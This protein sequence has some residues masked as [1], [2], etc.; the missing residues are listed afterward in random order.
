MFEDPSAIAMPREPILKGPI[1]L[2]ISEVS[3][4]SGGKLFAGYA[5]NSINTTFHGGSHIHQHSGRVP[6]EK[7]DLLN[8]YRA[9][10]TTRNSC[11][12]AIDCS[13]SE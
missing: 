13:V 1:T 12:P 7:F 3:A 9:S 8:N 6:S 11:E 4:E 2:N 5:D 10:R